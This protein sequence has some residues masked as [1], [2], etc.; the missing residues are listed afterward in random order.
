MKEV[1]TFLKKR[2][3]EIKKTKSIVSLFKDTTDIM[4]SK[5]VDT[6]LEEAPITEGANFT[7]VSKQ[8][9]NAVSEIIK[10][11]PQRV[12]ST[13]YEEDT[14]YSQFMGMTQQLLFSD[15]SAEN[16]Q[17][18]VSLANKNMA[19]ETRNAREQAHLLKDKMTTFLNDF[20]NQVEAHPNPEMLD[21]TDVSNNVLREV[22]EAKDKMTQLQAR[23]L[24][25]QDFSDFR[26]SQLKNILAAAK[27]KIPNKEMVSVFNPDTGTLLNSIEEFRAKL[28]DINKIKSQIQSYKD[29]V[30]NT[31]KPGEVFLS[32]FTQIYNMFKSLE[33]ELEISPSLNTSSALTTFSNMKSKLDSIS[34]FISLLGTKKFTT[35]LSDES[36][37]AV[38]QVD[39]FTESLQELPDPTDKVDD[40]EYSAK[41]MIRTAERY[42]TGAFKQEALPILD[43]LEEKMD[44][45][46]SII[47]ENLDT[48]ETIS[49]IFDPPQ[50]SDVIAYMDALGTVA[51][52]AMDALLTGDINSFQKTMESPTMLTQAGQAITEMKSFATN[53][54]DKMS[55]IDKNMFGVVSSYLAGEHKRAMMS[56]WIGNTAARRSKALTS[57][58][59]TV[60]KFIRPVEKL[61]NILGSKFN[62]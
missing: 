5:L 12:K 29:N 4:S 39:K 14:M 42:I 15:D 34:G 28:N 17:S 44:E 47:E 36:N 31:V 54:A 11:V 62:V 32:N 30:M 53:N 26:I 13:T 9:A 1:N 10:E 8:V 19:T 41:A 24:N 46:F 55:I 51:P 7:Q 3:D 23:V 37:I 52:A 27:D 25:K 38:E 20:R 60:N 45:G 57:L 6:V 16:I 21:I 58:D 18:L 33:N 50:T 48:F 40:I 61:V 22:S 35:A 2:V 56:L 49:N 59:L 43:Q